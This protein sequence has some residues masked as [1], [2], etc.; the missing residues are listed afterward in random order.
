MGLTQGAHIEPLKALIYNPTIKP[1]TGKSQVYGIGPGSLLAGFGLGFVAIAEA[2]AGSDSWGTR[3]C[4]LG[5]KFNTMLFTT[6]WSV[7]H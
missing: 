3:K 4:T 2:A 6:P 1:D 5:A 7:I